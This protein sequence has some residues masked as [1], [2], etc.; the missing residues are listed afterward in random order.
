LVLINYLNVVA[1]EGGPAAEAMLRALYGDVNDDSFC[2]ADDVL[3]VI[4]HLNGEPF[5]AA[6]G[7]SIEFIPMPAAAT[8]A[9]PTAPLRDRI[10]ADLAAEWSS[11]EESLSDLAEE[12]ASA[13]R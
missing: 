9:R 13:W 2:T 5:P 7:E 6:E 12:V 4:N 11:L 1:N 3:A 10:F 8:G